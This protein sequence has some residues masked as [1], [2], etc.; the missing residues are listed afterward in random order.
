MCTLFVIETITDGLNIIQVFTHGRVW[1]ESC[2]AF[3]AVVEEEAMVCFP[4]AFAGW[5]VVI[6]V[7]CVYYPR[8]CYVV[9]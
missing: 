9:L 7:I 4:I 6:V 5:K 3:H 2:R 1:E 8:H